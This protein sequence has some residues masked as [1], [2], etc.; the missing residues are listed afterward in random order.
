M[1][2]LSGD[3]GRETVIRIF[4]MEKIYF[5]IKIYKKTPLKEN[6]IT[7]HAPVGTYTQVLFWKVTHHVRGS[8]SFY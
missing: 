2:D 8:F 3:E 1:E 7:A 6:E 4:C 5:L